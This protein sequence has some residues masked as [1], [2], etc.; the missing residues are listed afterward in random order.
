MEVSLAWEYFLFT[1]LTS[2]AT[3]QMVASIKNKE[4]LRI[5]KGRNFT[6][7]ISLILIVLSF[8]WFFWVRDRDVQS[9]ME[10]AQLSTVFGLG[11]FSSLVGTKILKTI[12]EHNKT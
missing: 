3:L 6:I 5:L 1:S 12:Y 2:F 8:F 11:A 4:N 7:I 9:Y 10:G